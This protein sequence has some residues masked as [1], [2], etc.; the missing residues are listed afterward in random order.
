[1][2]DASTD[3]RRRRGRGPSWPQAVIDQAIGMRELGDTIE[4]TVA[5]LKESGHDVPYTTVARWTAHL[6][7]ADT[8]GRWT[9]ADA[10]RTTEPDP[11]VVMAELGAVILSTGGRVTGMTRDEARWVT[12]L[13]KVD[14]DM[15][16]HAPATTWQLAR[17]Y[18]RAIAPEP[19]DGSAPKR[20]RRTPS[21]I[22]DVQTRD[23]DLAVA[24]AEARWPGLTDKLAALGR[25]AMQTT[26]ELAARRN[27]FLDG[28]PQKDGG[29]RAAKEARKGPRR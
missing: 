26:N 5:A 24:A 11:V 1:M 3:Y 15:A 7:P 6:E 27:P 4:A 17:A 28:T 9:L 20:P 22:A 2:S 13:A 23:R 18:I 8:S 10:A 25:K 14:P 12:L 16:A 21:H 29:A 19:D